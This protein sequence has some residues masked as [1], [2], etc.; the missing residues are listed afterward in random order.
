MHLCREHFEEDVQRKIREALRKTRLFGPGSRIAVG[1]DGGR[2]SATTAFALKHL[3]ASRRDIELLAVIIDEGRKISPTADQA[4]QVAE[5]LEIPY[6][7]RSLRP[8]P[9]ALDDLPCRTLPGQVPSAK[10]MQMLFGT[11]Q[12]NAA[13]ILAT[14]EC[15]DDEALEIFIGYLQGDAEAA[16]PEVALKGA[17][18]GENVARIK[19]LRRIPEK[20]VRLYAIG[21]DLGFDDAGERPPA[22]AL[23]RE[24]KRLLFEFDCRHPGTNYSLLRGLE[25]GLALEGAGKGKAFK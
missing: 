15:L 25:K 9:A 5:G 23:R 21:H 3:F 24:A 16:L 14:G 11:A 2:N 18:E 10:K 20:E 13:G 6:V 7:L 12:E 19:P 8:L 17:G 22:D 4:R 1:L